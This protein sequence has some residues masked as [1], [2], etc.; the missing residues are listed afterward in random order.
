MPV[1]PRDKDRTRDTRR[2]TN[3]SLEHLKGL[4]QLG[5]LDLSNN[6]ITDA[7][8]E[9]LEGLAQLGYLNLKGTKVTPKGMQ[10]I[11]RASPRCSFDR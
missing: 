7:G 5:Y 8:L 1:P 9:H 10:E 4:T 11:K 6:E 2:F 3:A